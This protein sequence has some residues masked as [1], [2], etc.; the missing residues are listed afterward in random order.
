LPLA[1]RLKPE[2]G[3]KK[4]AVFQVN[5]SRGRSEGRQLTVVPHSVV[6]GG[7]EA[8]DLVVIRVGQL[9]RQFAA[10]TVGCFVQ[11]PRKFR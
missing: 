3:Q 9:S 5:E 6:E 1:L 2:T 4:F 10:D 8:V 11:Q 7:R